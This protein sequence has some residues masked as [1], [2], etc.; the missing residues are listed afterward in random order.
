MAVPK[1]DEL[2]TPVIQALQKLGGSGSVSEIEE[3]VAEILKL[4]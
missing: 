4:S 2:C 1:F 3:K